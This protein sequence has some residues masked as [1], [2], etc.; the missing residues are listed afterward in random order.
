MI[1][2]D[3]GC[4]PHGHEVS[5]ERLI[6]RYAPDV[7]YGFDPYPELVEGET[8]RSLERVGAR[9][10]HGVRILLERKAAW[11]FDGE[12]EMTLVPGERAWDS[13][14][15][16]DKNSRREWQQGALVSV[17]C[18]D[19]AR[20]LREVEPV[21]EGLILKMDIEGAEFPLCEHLIGTHTDALV[22]RLLVEWHDQ[23]MGYPPERRSA[24]EERLRCPVEEWML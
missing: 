4:Y 1:V 18:F 15:M 21:G 17:P 7:L 13:T 24:L 16:R 5:I 9:T 23:K 12:V 14:L 8:F 10:P 22:G 11:T 20:F 3:L 6:D 19:I 2:V